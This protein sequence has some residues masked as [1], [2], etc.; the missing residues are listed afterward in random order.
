VCCFVPSTVA[1]AGASASCMTSCPGTFSQ[2]QVCRN[3]CECGGSTACGIPAGGSAAKC[4][5]LS[6]ATCG[7]YCP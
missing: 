2:V 1:G 3:S 4:S 6:I 7:G 5:P